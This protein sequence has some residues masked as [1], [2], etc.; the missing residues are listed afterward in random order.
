MLRRGIPVATL[1][2]V[3]MVLASCSSSGSQYSQRPTEPA[4]VHTAAPVTAS[5]GV[6]AGGPQMDLNRNSGAVGD[7]IGITIRNCAV[8]PGGQDWLTWHDQRQDRAARAHQELTPAFTKLPFRRDGNSLTAT[9]LVLPTYA[10]GL[11]VLDKFCANNGNAV[12]TFTVQPRKRDGCNATAL[13]GSLTG[14]QRGG[15]TDVYLVALKNHAERSCQLFNTPDLLEGQNL[16]GDT[17]RVYLR[18][19]EGGF[20][21]VHRPAP[22]ALGQSEH[23]FLYVI[24]G[25]CPSALH[26][27]TNLRMHLTTGW[28]RI[29]TSPHHPI[30]VCS[31]NTSVADPV[32][33]EASL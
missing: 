29:D 23:Y 16:A 26:T 7:S 3:A 24:D 5:P 15:G 1:S 18:H 14:P 21:S 28:L 17:E 8:V 20:A 10:L 4:L 12:A 11:G 31:Q 6:S 19:A 9:F 33:P 2:A 27:L 32:G 30:R 25:A 13:V 22:A